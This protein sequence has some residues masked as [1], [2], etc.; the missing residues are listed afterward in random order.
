MVVR[1]LIQSVKPPSQSINSALKVFARSHCP[2]TKNKLSAES[3]VHIDLGK[4]FGAAKVILRVTEQ[5]N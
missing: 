4:L 1:Q 2:N 5:D 3:K